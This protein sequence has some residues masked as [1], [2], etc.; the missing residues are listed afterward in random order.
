MSILAI[1]IILALVAFLVYTVDPYGEYHSGKNNSSHRQSDK[2]KNGA[3]HRSCNNDS[4]KHES[5]ESKT[6]KVEKTK[7][8]KSIAKRLIQLPAINEKGE[9]GSIN[10]ECYVLGDSF[11]FLKNLIKEIDRMEFAELHYVNTVNAI[12]DL[13]DGVKKAVTEEDLMEVYSDFMDYLYSVEDSMRTEYNEPI[14]DDPEVDV[15]YD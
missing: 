15:E 7:K 3:A 13:N 1:I 6:A 11:E 9:L 8:S 5:Y 14:E 2:D 12:S 10:I 4:T